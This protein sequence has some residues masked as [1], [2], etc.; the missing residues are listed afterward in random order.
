MLY[1]AEEILSA[2]KVILK[3][4]FHKLVTSTNWSEIDCFQKPVKNFV[5]FTTTWQLPILATVSKK[6]VNSILEETNNLTNLKMITIS[7]MS[8][9]WLPFNNKKNNVLFWK[10]IN[11]IS[12]IRFYVPYKTQPAH[13]H[14]EIYAF[15]DSL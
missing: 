5:F 6:R 1:L 12:F 15:I 8:C 9:V 3:G 13:K 10:E 14:Y 7:I 11:N 4:S 2:Q